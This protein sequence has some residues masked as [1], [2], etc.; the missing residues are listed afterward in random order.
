VLE[1][2]SV[3]GHGVDGIAN[4]KALID[5]NGPLPET[6]MAHSPSGSVHYFF[7]HP[8]KGL[9]RNSASTLAPGVDVRGEG[10]MVIVAVP[11]VN[12]IRAYW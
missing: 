12:Q 7:T 10:G 9:V 4:L 5:A 1:A 11:V 2:D 6:R 8:H 3:K